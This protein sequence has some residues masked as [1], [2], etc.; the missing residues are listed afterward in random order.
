MTRNPTEMSVAAREVHRI[1]RKFA[2]AAEQKVKM[3]RKLYRAIDSSN[4]MVDSFILST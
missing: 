1:I 2:L 3:G 4:E